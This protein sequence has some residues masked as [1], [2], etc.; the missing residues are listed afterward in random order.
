MARWRWYGGALAILSSLCA[1]GAMPSGLYSLDYLRTDSRVSIQRKFYE[2]EGN[3]LTEIKRVIGTQGPVDQYGIR[4]DAYTSWHIRWE[5]PTSDSGQLLLKETKAYATIEI[6][7][8]ALSADTVLNADDFAAWERYRAAID[9]HEEQHAQFAT[10]TRAKIQRKIRE[11]ARSGR[12]I[13][14]IQAN[15][16]G[17][18][19][20]EQLRREDLR[21][22]Q[23]TDHGRTD[24]V[25]LH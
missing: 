5:W 4:R 10:R 3:T 25:H 9:R 7:I 22:D 23:K 15:A 6:R 18:R 1:A 13:T 21:F 12:A 24:G 11:A 8:P 2:I 20:L 19:L 17:Y 14:A 16:I